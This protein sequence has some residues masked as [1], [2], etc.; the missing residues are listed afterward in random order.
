MNNYYKQVTELTLN[1]GESSIEKA[2]KNRR[3]QQGTG[4]AGTSGTSFKL[5]K[6]MVKDKNQ[7]EQNL[8]GSSIDNNTF[9]LNY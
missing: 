5:K 2:L 6:V 1:L 9:N 4:L 7:D 8:E 3:L